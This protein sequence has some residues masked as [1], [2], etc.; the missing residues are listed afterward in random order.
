MA[1]WRVYILDMMKNKIEIISY[2]LNKYHSDM[3]NK[4]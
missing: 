4:K 1:S 3:K 2:R